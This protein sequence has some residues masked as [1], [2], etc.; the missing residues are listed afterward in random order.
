VFLSPSAQ[1]NGEENEQ[2]TRRA[3]R[4]GNDK[5]KRGGKNNRGRNDGVAKALNFNFTGKKNTKGK[6]KNNKRPNVRT[7]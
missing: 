2:Q 6:R 3:I 1:T 5:E 7:Q 4:G